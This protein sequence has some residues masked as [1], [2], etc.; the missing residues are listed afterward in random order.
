MLRPARKR[1]TTELRR[2][3]LDEWAALTEFG[4]ESFDRGVFTCALIQVM[5]NYVHQVDLSEVCA[6]W[7]VCCRS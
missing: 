4:K 2:E 5:E 3:A 1:T 7:A 6:Q